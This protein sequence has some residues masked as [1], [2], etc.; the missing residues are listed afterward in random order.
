[1]KSGFMVQC[2]QGFSGPIKRLI[3]SNVT[4][5][6]CCAR[7]KCARDSQ[8]CTKTFENEDKAAGICSEALSKD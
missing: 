1:M 7:G 8:E 3:G 5:R 4:R 2:N 6:V